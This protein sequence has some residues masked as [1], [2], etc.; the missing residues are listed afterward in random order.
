[1]KLNAVKRYIALHK[2]LLAEKSALEQQL[3]AINQAL[4]GTGPLRTPRGAARA[5]GAV[6]RRRRNRL[7]LR[8]AVLQVTSAKPMSKPDI[9]AAVTKLGYRFTT[10]NPINS[11]NAVLYKDRFKNYGGKYGPVK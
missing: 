6:R 1:M 2:A 11:L 10:K 4:G 5:N 9:L 7:S 8:K 3:E